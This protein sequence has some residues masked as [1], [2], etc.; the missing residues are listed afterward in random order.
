MIELTGEYQLLNSRKE[1]IEELCRPGRKTRV[2]GQTGRRDDPRG[3][4]T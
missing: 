1:L 3:G 2:V 4:T